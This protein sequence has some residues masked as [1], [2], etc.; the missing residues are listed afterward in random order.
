MDIQNKAGR[1]AV[2]TALSAATLVATTFAPVHASQTVAVPQTYPA[3]MIIIK[4]SE[5]KLYLTNGDGTA[6]RYPVAI[7]KTGKAWRG[8]TFIEGKF[9]HPD[10]APPASV[11]PVTR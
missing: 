5:R 6:I 10:W 4:Q 1:L 11:S 3:G 2:I 7:G 9:V 8:Q